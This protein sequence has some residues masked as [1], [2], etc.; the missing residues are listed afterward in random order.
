MTMHFLRSTTAVLGLGLLLSA[1]IGHRAD[2][3]AAHVPGGSASVGD[4]G[5]TSA[6]MAPPADE[7]QAGTVLGQDTFNR[8]DG[9]LGPN[10]TVIDSTP[11]IVNGHV[12]EAF[13][14]D[15]WDSIPI[16]T[17]IAWP[18]DQYSEVAV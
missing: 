18:A 17:A 9:G 10:W 7:Q 8:A 13:A 16:Y 5:G 4:I 1:T 12:E 3:I 6:A 2:A 14:G 15:G 11:R